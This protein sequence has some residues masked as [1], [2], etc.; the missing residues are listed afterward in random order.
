MAQIEQ[1]GKNQRAIGLL[2][3]WMADETDYD[4]KAW[5]RLRRRLRIGRNVRPVVVSPERFLEMAQSEQVVGRSRELVIGA[6]LWAA[7]AG[8]AGKN[9]T[10]DQRQ[11]KFDARMDALR[12]ANFKGVVEFIEAGS[13]FGVNVATNWSFGPQQMSF[14]ARGEIDFTKPAR[15]P[16]TT[17]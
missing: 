14:R 13:P 15:L 8:C 1:H 10:F 12:Q 11:Q 2:R 4:K 5:H 17:P 9:D 7:L 3:S 6:M 16:V